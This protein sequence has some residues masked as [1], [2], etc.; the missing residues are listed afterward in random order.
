LTIV[1]ELQIREQINNG[2]NNGRKKAKKRKIEVSSLQK[3]CSER[4]DLQLRD[5]QERRD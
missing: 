5:M 4:R 1:S 2:Q 3:V